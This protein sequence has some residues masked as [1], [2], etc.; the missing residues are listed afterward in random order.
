MPAVQEGGAYRW[1]V[2]ALLFIAYVL[3]AVDAGVIKLLAEPIKHDLGLSDTQLGLLQ[4][5]AFAM[6]YAIAAIP[7]GLIVDRTKRR[8]WVIAGGIVFWSAMTMMC[9]VARSFGQLFAA[10][11]GVGMGEAALSPTAY[12][13]IGDYFNAQKRPLAN[14]F[15]AI[16]YSV[17]AALAV[18]IGGMLLSYFMKTG[19]GHF[20]ILGL[21]KPWQAVFVCV[22]LPGLVVALLMLTIR[23]PVRRED[24]R[25]EVVAGAKVSF[26]EAFTYLMQNWRL[27][28]ML[29]GTISLVGALAIGASAWYPAFLMRTYSW[30]IGQVTKIYGFALLIFGVMGTL[31]GGWLSS[32]LIARGRRDAN[33]MIVLATILLKAIPLLAAPLMPTGELAVAMIA[34]STLIGQGA[35]G[36]MIAAIQE[37]TPNRL[38]GQIIAIALLFVNLVGVGGG[39]LLFGVL[40]E[41]AFTGT[42]SLRWALLTGTAIMLPIIVINLLTGMRHYRA[43]L[44]RNAG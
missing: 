5:F 38:R 31:T 43:A 4:G 22:A 39:A 37:V 35:Q 23:E 21:V 14:A 7:L 42:D 3:S 30:S 8:N 36:V 1:Y 28:L 18:I 13:L 33:M 34:L 24:R 9:G 2:V 6:T 40:S 41:H 11:I 27:Y 25:H 10:R 15:Y 20:P 29:I 17:G 12:S 44:E 26:G 19:G 16:G 32:R